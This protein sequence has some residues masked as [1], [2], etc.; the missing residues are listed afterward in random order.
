MSHAVVIGGGPNGLAA[1]IV[2]ASKGR[3]VTVYEARDELGGRCHLLGDTSCVQDWALKALKLRLERTPVSTLHQATGGEVRQIDD[4]VPGV[5]NWRNE[6]ARFAPLVNALSSSP[7][8]DIRKHASLLS[9]VTPAMSALKLGRSGALELARIGPL[10]AE[11]WLDE[12]GVPRWAQ[13][14]MCAPALNGTWMGPRSP[15]SALALLILHRS[16]KRF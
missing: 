4:T 8:P 1:A 9:L 3:Q 7:P 2:L 13:A 16:M 10:C 6:V 12:W 14:A 11:D 15:T 5:R